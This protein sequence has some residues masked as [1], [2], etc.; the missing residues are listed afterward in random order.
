MHVYHSGISTVVVYKWISSFLVWGLFVAIMIIIIIIVIFT[1]NDPLPKC[2]KSNSV[3]EWSF[4]TS[5]CII[6][7]FRSDCFSNNLLCTLNT[8]YRNILK[9]GFD[10]ENLHITR[11]VGVRV[12][13]FGASMVY[14]NRKCQT[15]CCCQF[16]CGEFPNSH[17]WP[18]FLNK[19]LTHK[20]L[21]KGKIFIHFE[22]IAQL[23]ALAFYQICLAI[24]EC[25]QIYQ[26]LK[27]IKMLFSQR[28]VVK[29]LLNNEPYGLFWARPHYLNTKPLLSMVRYFS[30]LLKSSCI[31]LSGV[32]SFSVD[33]Q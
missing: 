7:V 23:M 13:R 16:L 24:N 19:I 12:R 9:R 5:L 3:L 26:K 21:D 29:G 4:Q 28:L 15:F 33:I 25:I 30:L 14:P 32:Q 8:E 11:Y 2:G 18:M 22:A 31:P 10:S 1:E 17:Y 20:C 6:V 27:P